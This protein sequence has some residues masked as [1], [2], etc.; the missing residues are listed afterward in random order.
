VQEKPSRMILILLFGR[1]SY[2][3][4]ISDGISRSTKIATAT[5]RVENKQ[6]SRVRPL[7]RVMAKII[8]SLF[9][10]LSSKKPITR[11]GMSYM[12]R[13]RNWGTLSSIG[14]SAASVYNG[15]VFS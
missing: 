5:K 2:Y 10:Q 1:I 4:S 12:A 7:A 8:P 3:T 15:A 6:A 14:A 13:L 11:T 9:S